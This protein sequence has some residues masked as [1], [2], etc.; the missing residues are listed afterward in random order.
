METSA[1]CLIRYR[2]LIQSWPQIYNI[3]V[4]SCSC[5]KHSKYSIASIPT[6]RIPV[7]MDTD[8]DSCDWSA[9]V[10]ASMI[11]SF[12]PIFAMVVKLLNTFSFFNDYRC[13]ASGLSA[14]K[15]SCCLPY[16][17][18]SKLGNQSRSSRRNESVRRVDSVVY[19]PKRRFDW[20]T[21]MW[22]K[23][24]LTQTPRCLSSAVRDQM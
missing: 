1:H 17:S 14:L 2:I 15:F 4:D 8:C 18:T 5:V 22:V 11:L 7:G 24:Y 20:S 19:S 13:T 6:R 10:A 12:S 21:L 3:K 9:R 16:D 23:A